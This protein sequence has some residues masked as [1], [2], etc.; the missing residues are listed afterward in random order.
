MRSFSSVLLLVPQVLVSQVLL[1]SLLLFMLEDAEE[2]EEV[3]E[4][5]E[6]THLEVE[7]VKKISSG[8]GSEA[9]RV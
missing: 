3:E 6:E 8:A 9:V 1:Q 7:A 5:E 2:L 4:L